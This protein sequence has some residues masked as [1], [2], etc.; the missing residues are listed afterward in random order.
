MQTK[1][2]PENL[3][4]SNQIHLYLKNTSTLFSVNEKRAFENKVQLYLLYY[5][6]STQFRWNLP[7]K[8]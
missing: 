1:D 8:H 5:R 3:L 2:L 7:L 6:D 4:V